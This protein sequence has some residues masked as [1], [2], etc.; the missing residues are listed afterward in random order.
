MGGRILL[1]LAVYSFIY[2]SCC[3]LNSE[4]ND[5]FCLWKSRGSGG[6]G[7][8]GVRRVRQGGSGGWS[9]A[10]LVSK[11]IPLALQCHR[12]QGRGEVEVMRGNKTRSELGSRNSGPSS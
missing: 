10:V 4:Q 2:F 5:L 3:L 12:S 8:Q 9:C 7:K 1:A 6:D 11:G